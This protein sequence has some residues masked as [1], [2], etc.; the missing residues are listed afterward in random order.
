MGIIYEHDRVDD[1]DSESREEDE[2]YSSELSKEEKFIVFRERLNKEQG[3]FW[4]PINMVNPDQGS[5]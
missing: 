3:W 2:Y 1:T 4:F 5:S